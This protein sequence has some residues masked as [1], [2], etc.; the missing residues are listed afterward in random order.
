MSK[1]AALEPPS[2]S[3]SGG[4]DD[5]GSGR[6]EEDEA[7]E[8]NSSTIR[9]PRKAFASTSSRGKTLRP[10]TRLVPPSGTTAPPTKTSSLPLAPVLE[11]YSDL[12]PSPSPSSP[13]ATSAAAEA[14][15]VFTTRLAQFKQKAASKKQLLRPEDFDPSSASFGTAVGQKAIA[16]ERE[17]LGRYSELE[18][19]EDDYSDLFGEKETG[20]GTPRTVRVSSG[21]GGGGAR[22]EGGWE[23]DFEDGF[24]V[25]GEDLRL[26]T[27]LS[28][29]S[30]VRPFSSLSL[31]RRFSRRTTTDGD[32]M[33][34]GARRRRFR[35]RRPLRRPRPLNLNLPPLSLPLRLQLPDVPL[36]PTR[37][38]GEPRA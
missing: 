6:S 37:P 15:D 23:E 32:V 30:W 31:S 25:E 33:T 9:P 12:L 21:G 24:E 29:R 17:G 19:E 38:H 10:S 35:R 20:L 13:T 11:D 18:G 5:L 16:R 26:N 1:I 4:G 34:R 8:E 14:E 27:R 28:S 2:S 36:F 7:E 22:G 3:G